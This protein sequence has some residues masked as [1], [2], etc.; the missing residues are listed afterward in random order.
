MSA[1]ARQIFFFFQ[2]NCESNS[3]LRSGNACSP[4]WHRKRTLSFW[5]SICVIPLPRCEVVDKIINMQVGHSRPC[6]GR[7]SSWFSCQT[8]D[9]SRTMKVTWYEIYLKKM[10]PRQPLSLETPYTINYCY[11]AVM[12]NYY[13]SGF[14]AKTDAASRHIYGNTERQFATACQV[15]ST[16]ICFYTTTSLYR[17]FISRRVWW[18][19]AISSFSSR[20]PIYRKYSFVR[21]NCLSFSLLVFFYHFNC[22]RGLGRGCGR[23]KRTS[24]AVWHVSQQ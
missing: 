16:R 10:R 5:P 8:K 24:K 21:P 9:L 12:R 2:L 6:C 23:V 1:I 20:P 19:A 11:P 3:T 14:S 22:R 18:P 4:L 7:A 13:F 17:C 15:Q